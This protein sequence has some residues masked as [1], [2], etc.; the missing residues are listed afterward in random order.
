MNFKN[1]LKELNRRHVIKAAISYVVF[2]WVL[3]QAASILFPAIGWGQVA[4]RFLLI[5]LI[6]GFPVWIVFAY[7]FDWTPSGIKKTQDFTEDTFDK[8]STSKRMNAV[9][10]FGLSLAVLL[11][12]TDRVFNFTTT[13]KIGENDKSIAVLAFADMSP[14]KDQEYFSDG[15][16]EEILNLLAKVKDLKVISRTSSFAYKG[17]EENIK[18]I[19]K[20]LKVSYVLEG[21][22]RKSENTLR[23]TSQLINAKDGSHVWSETYDREMSDI[24]KIQDEIADNVSQRLKATLLDE[25]EP[26]TP[27]PNAYDYYL[28][29]MF[30]WN[31]LTEE[32][33]D[34]SM[35]YF[36]MARDI[37]PKYA[38][39]YA[40]IANVWVGKAQQG[41]AS[42]V[43]ALPKIEEAV[44]KAL[45]LD[46]TSA[47]IYETKAWSSW[48]KWNFKEIEVAYRKA[49]QL[50]PNFSR[51]RA[52]F[53]QML[54]SL[55]KPDEAMQHMEI[56]LKLDP[57][58]SLYK[59]I[60]G[61]NLNFTRQYDKAIDILEPTLKTSPHDPVALSTLRTSY[62]MKGMYAKAMDVWKASYDAKNDHKAVEVLAKGEA[63][64]GYHKALED[65]AELLID[66]SDSM[67]VTPW[68]IATIYTRAGQKDKAL[69]WLEK[70]FAYHDTNM[71]YIGIDPIFDIFKG[72]PRFLKLIKKMNLP[73]GNHLI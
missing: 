44:E 48:V 7:I 10:I 18:Q 4:I 68:Q 14:D 25:M 36:E 15:I 2:S 27:D 23:I 33:L 60:Y 70:A 56:A 41:L 64:G 63:E 9:I 55:N 54:I 12:I 30:Y 50:N 21:S 53:S 72:D 69:V 34:K 11:L 32:S 26:M 38:L 46:S 3:I 24:F 22:V 37:D 17:K 47:E 19:G 35:Q 67:F 42:Y 13:F 40:G 59:A 66:R 28:K 16:S 31:N 62:H 45:A 8:K 58:N 65:L 51:A 39:A 71:P 49:I 1:Y 29:G 43:E 20:E 6:I 5:I 61:M 52:Y 73:L 57:F